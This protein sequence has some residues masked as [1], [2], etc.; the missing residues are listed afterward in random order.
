MLAGKL[1]QPTHC[2]FAV[3]LSVDAELTD[4]LEA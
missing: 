3:V 2:L 1:A 4:F